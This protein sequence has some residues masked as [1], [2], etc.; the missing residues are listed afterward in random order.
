MK[1]NEEQAGAP[2]IPPEPEGSEA[3]TGL[4]GLHTWKAVYF[5]VLACFAAS[6]GLLVILTRIYL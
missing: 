4:P 5:F 1:L 3:P 6:V 2:E